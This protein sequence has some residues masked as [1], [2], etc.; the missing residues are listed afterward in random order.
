VNADV[1]ALAARIRE[2]G[3]P[4]LEALSISD[5]RS[6]TAPFLRMQGE[7]QAVAEVVNRPVPGGDGPVAARIYRPLLDGV[8]PAIVYF[9]G[10]GWVIGDLEIADRTCRELANATGAVVVSLDY[11]LA[12]EHPFPAAHD[13]CVAATEWVHR[14]ANML[15]VDPRRVAVAGDSAGG[16][17]AAAAA[18][19]LR[20][21][22]PL[23]AQLLV[24]PVLDADFTTPGYRRRKDDEML[25]QSTMRWFWEQ[26]SAA[27]DAR[28]DARAAPLRARD[29]RGAAPAFI[30]SC[31]FDPLRDQS[32]RYVQRLR[33]DRVP[34]T[35]RDYEGLMHG[36]LWMMAATPSAR[37]VFDGLVTAARELLRGER[38]V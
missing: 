18:L 34:V 30:A 9:H 10:G 21:R 12:P 19:T 35:W 36:G 24:Y 28:F 7:P 16:N 8:L 25:P 32:K 2:V 13:D 31:E 27:A 15:G 14:E 33:A 4:R 3:R 1:A 23:A 37:I 22:V 20:G 29:L 11:R 5:A 26:Y 6:S 38:P 17:L